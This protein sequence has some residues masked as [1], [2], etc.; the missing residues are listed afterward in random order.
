MRKPFFDSPDS[1]LTFKKYIDMKTEKKPKTVTIPKDFW[2]D[3]YEC[4]MHLPKRLAKYP[5]S[6]VVYSERTGSMCELI[7]RALYYVSVVSAAH[8]S[9]QVSSA[10]SLLKALHKSGVLSEEEQEEA[11]CSGVKLS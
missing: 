11:I 8:L 9:N 10:K 3:C 4:D 1:S 7:E 5:K 6:Y 2:D